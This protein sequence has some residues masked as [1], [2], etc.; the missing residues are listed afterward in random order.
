[1]I[2]TVL[3][4]STQRSDAFPRGAPPNVCDSSAPAVGPHGQPQDNSTNPYK[5][6]VKE[7]IV[8]AGG[9]VSLEIVKI[10]QAS[11]DFKGF[12][13]NARD[14]ADGKIVGKFQASG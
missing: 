7:Q 3:I 9:V 12:I 2:G 10:D 5:L 14:T 13:V 1:M 4:V 6:I 11:P 8:P